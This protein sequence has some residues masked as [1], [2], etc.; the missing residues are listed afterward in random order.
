[1]RTGH[2]RENKAEV[3]MESCLTITDYRLKGPLF[4]CQAN[5]CKDLQFYGLPLTKPV[6]RN[7]CNFNLDY[8]V[9]DGNCSSVVS[10]NIFSALKVLKKFKKYLP[11]FWGFFCVFFF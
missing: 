5:S 8:S 10:K 9:T 11:G 1:M 4:G 6:T 3:A 7:S 2:I